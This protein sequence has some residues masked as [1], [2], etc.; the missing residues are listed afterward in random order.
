[1]VKTTTSI[2][3]CTTSTVDVWWVSLVLLVVLFGVVFV[4]VL[5]YMKKC[6]KTVQSVK[7]GSDD[8]LGNFL[9]FNWVDGVIKVF[10]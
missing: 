8:A 5:V 3:A 6:G 2:P 4:G 10:I 7:V 9:I 1:M